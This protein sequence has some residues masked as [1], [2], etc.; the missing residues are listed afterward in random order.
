MARQP[1]PLMGLGP[2]Q[3]C[4]DRTVPSALSA[5]EAH[6]SFT[7]AQSPR[8]I[9]VGVPA[10]IPNQTEPDSLEPRLCAADY[11]EVKVR[12]LG[13]DPSVPAISAD[14]RFRRQTVLPWALPLSGLPD[15]PRGAAWRARPRTRSS[16][17]ARSSLEAALR[18]WA[19][20]VAMAGLCGTPLVRGESSRSRAARSSATPG[21]RCLAL[22]ISSL[23]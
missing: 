7:P 9:F 22:P 11:V 1:A 20:T 3:L 19:W 17:V 10:A 5:A 18:S 12:L 8:L 6:V 16:A 4:S 15:T 2:S 23:Q 14:G 13:F 21:G